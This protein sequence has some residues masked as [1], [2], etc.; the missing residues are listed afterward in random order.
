[1]NFDIIQIKT[2]GDYIMT[3]TLM[4]QGLEN[5]DHSLWAQNF[6]HIAHMASH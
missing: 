4:H 5:T 6:C 3:E 2:A 1:M